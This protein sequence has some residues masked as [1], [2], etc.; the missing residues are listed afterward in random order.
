MKIYKKIFFNF[1]HQN[2]LCQND[3]FFLSV[4]P[5][6]EFS[7]SQPFS[8]EFIISESEEISEISVS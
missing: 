3:F 5:L 8:S 2:F 1:F 7:S 6:P 4:F